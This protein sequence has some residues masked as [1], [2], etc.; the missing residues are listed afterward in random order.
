MELEPG[1]T[2]PADS[3]IIWLTSNFNVQ[4]ASLT[5]ESTPVLK[6][7][8]ALEE[9]DIPLADR[10]N[11]VYMGTSVSS[12]KAKGMVVETG[13][14]TELGKIAGMIQDIG[15]ESTPLQKKLDE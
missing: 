13:M 2:P 8:L 9:K 10:A 1:H 15:K 5:G 11:M 4:E 6:T 3:R 14:R 12:G 7:N